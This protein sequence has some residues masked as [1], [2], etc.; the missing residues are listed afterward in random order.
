MSRFFRRKRFCR[1][2]A[3]GV[4]EID[5][6]DLNTLKVILRRPARSCRAH[7][8]H[9]GA[10]STPTGNGHQAGEVPRAASLL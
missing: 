10:L 4:K 2:T 8:R 9:E 3:E 6:K 1:F 5:Y 7:L